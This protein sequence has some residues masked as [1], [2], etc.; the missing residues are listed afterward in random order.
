MDVK[1][2]IFVSSVKAG[3]T[4]VRGNL[5]TEITKE[6]RMEFMERP[7]EKQKLDF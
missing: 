2:F 7:K 3:G 6:N 1:R 5:N 4:K